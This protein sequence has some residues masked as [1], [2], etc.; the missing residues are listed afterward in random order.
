MKKTILLALAVALTAL[1][2]TACGG[3]GPKEYVDGT[4]TAQSEMYTAEEEGEGDG[5]GVVTLTISGGKITGCEFITY[6]PDGTV[7][8]EE[9]DKAVN[10]EV[11][12]PDFYNKAQKAVKA[13]PVYAEQLVETGSL[14]QVDAISGATYNDQQFKDAVDTALQQ[15]EK[16]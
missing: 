6:Q 15:A 12:N 3:G 9:Y 8:D 16:K 7:K 4:Y 1:L 13:A 10:G 11:G 5:Y 14:D 2:L